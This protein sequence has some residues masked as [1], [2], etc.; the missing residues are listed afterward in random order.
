MP[1][2]V[3]VR[4]LGYHGASGLSTKEGHVH[5]ASQKYDDLRRRL[6]NLGSVLV[7][8]SGGVDS[9]FLAFAAHAC[10]GERT[11]A[12]LGVSATVP[13]SELED[14][15]A[16]AEVLGLRLHEVAT[17]EL[18]DPRFQANPH[19]RCYYCKSELFSVLGETASAY[20][21]EWIADGT[22]A[23]DL[24]DHRPGRRAAA[25]YGVLSPLLDS[26]LGKEEIRLLSRD[27]GLPTWD[28]PAM[29]CLS[30]RIPYGS[31]ITPLMLERV[32]SAEAACRRLGLRQV[33]V[34]AHGEVARVE[35]DSSEMEQAF[36]L[37]RELARGVKAAGFLF[38]A[39]DLEGY[40]SGSFDLARTGSSS[41]D[42]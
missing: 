32:A 26:G 10:L 29:A 31:Q 35:V 17:H 12:V 16:T 18:A 21:M 15:R 23:D 37:R 9:T 6:E 34:R 4:P 33:R 5:G 39:Q 3:G 41:Q 28:K 7:A 11:L 20:G 13:T 40:R 42:Q 36:A 27:L 22:N 38:V 30:S 19:D 2:A 8:Y 14:A 25:A 1:A 24:N